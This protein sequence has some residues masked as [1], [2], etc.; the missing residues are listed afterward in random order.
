MENEIN[1]NISIFYSQSNWHLF[2]TK[3]LKPFIQQNKRIE[4]WYFSLSTNRGDHIIV[5]FIIDESKA[6]QLIEKASEYFSDFI[7]ETP[8]IPNKTLVSKNQF[9]LN[10]ENNT[11]QYGVYQNNINSIRLLKELSK[12]I[13]IVFENYKKDTFDFLTEIMIEVF[14]VFSVNMHDNKRCLFV[15]ETL[16]KMNTQN[17]WKTI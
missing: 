10:F 9:F 8:S 17:T 4:K 16:L 3:C 1:I 6:R 12:L 13:I 2:I 5:S 11:I 14:I 15:F 7:T